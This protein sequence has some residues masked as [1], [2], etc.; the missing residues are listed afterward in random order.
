MG[1]LK[2]QAAKAE[3][4]GQIR[5]ELRTRL[6]VVLASRIAQLDADQ[7]RTIARSPSLTGS[8]DRQSAAGRADGRGAL[9]R[10][11]RR[12]RSG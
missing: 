11:A 10:C 4:Y 12:L 7:T 1:T 6:R 5:D 2:R 8:I 9:G 3:R